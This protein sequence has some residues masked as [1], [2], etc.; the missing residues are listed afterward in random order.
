MFLICS[1]IY[2][3][4]YF[5]YFHYLFS[6]VLFHL[7]LFLFSMFDFPFLFFFGSP[8]IPVSGCAATTKLLCPLL[9]C[10]FCFKVVFSGSVKSKQTCF[11]GGVSGQGKQRQS[12]PIKSCP[13]SLYEFPHKSS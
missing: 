4:Q 10:A 2:Y 13:I 7:F 9:P 6:F 1:F 3:F 12:C 8:R 11:F 5:I